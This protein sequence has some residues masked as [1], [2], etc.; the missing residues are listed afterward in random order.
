MRPCPDKRCRNGEATPAECPIWQKNFSQAGNAAGTIDD[1]SLTLLPWSGSAMGMNDLAFLTSRGEPRVVGLVGAHNAGKTTM[2]AAWYQQMGREGKVAAGQ[3]AGSFSLEGWEAVAHALRW[4]GGQPHFPAHT[5]SGAGR[6]PGLLHLA[7]REASGSLKDHLFADAPGEW[8]ER[9][10]VDN[11]A[12]DA[13]G[14]RWLFQHA[15]LIAVVADCEALS[16]PQRGSTRSALVQL[17][18]RVAAERRG[19]PVSL[20]WSKADIAPPCSI[21]KAV[22]DAARLVMPDIVEFHISITDFVVDDIPH[23]AGSS[24]RAVLDWTLQPMGRGFEMPPVEI[25]TQDTFFHFEAR[26]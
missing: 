8:F 24:L 20:I 17:C 11:A 12:N 9:W 13:E 2:L 18:R 7:L 19:R 26:P 16:G 3:F 22:R 6:A 14:A 4:E 1:G 25:G 5:S 10:A 21:K 15:H 23:E